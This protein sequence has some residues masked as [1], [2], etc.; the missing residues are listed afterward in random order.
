MVSFAYVKSFESNDSIT[1]RVQSRCYAKP[2][3]LF[4]VTFN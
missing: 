2:S 1:F 3:I 4:Y